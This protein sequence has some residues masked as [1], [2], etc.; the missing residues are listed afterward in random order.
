MPTKHILAKL[1]QKYPDLERVADAVFRAIDLYNG[2]PYAIRYFDLRDDLLSAASRL[3]EYQEGLLG[4]S[5]FR[6]GSKSDLRWNHY[7]Y[8]VTAIVR[9]D[10]AFIRAKAIVESDREYARKIVLT[11]NELDDLLQDRHYRAGYSEDIPSDPL[12]V[13]VD[14]LEE[15]NLGF[16]VDQ[17]LQVPAVVRHIA[18]GR[19]RPVLRPPAEP[20]L[21][22]AEAAVSTDHLAN[23]AIREF[24][25]YP[26]RK[27]FDFGTVNLILG[28]N[29]AGKTSLL[30]AIEYLFCGRTRRMG[31][32]LP[33]TAVSGS[34]SPSNLTLH[35]KTTTRNEKLRSRHLVW[36]GKS[37]LR[38]IRLHDSFS[39]FNFLD[40]DAAVR[41]TVEKSR[42]HII[43]DL[44]QLLLGAE[45]AK[46]LDRFERVAQ[47]LTETKKDIENDILLRDTRRS[48]AA[49][50]LQ[51]LRESP[52]E[53][54]SL[55]SDLLVGLRNSKWLQL[56]SDKRQADE[57]SASL[58]S[59]LADVAILKGARGPILTDIAGLAAAV[60]S[61]T[62]TEQ[63]IDRLAKQDIARK[64]DE[65][66]MRRALQQVAKRIEA[67]NALAPIV[68]AGV[69]DLHLERRALERQ[70]REL[71]V[72]LPEAEAAVGGLP[73]D[74]TLR[75]RTLSTVVTEATEAVERMDERIQAAKEA[76]AEFE[77]GQTRLSSLR[78]RLR[79]SVREIIQH[80][81]DDEHCPVCQAEY[82][83]VELD[84][85]LQALTHE[86]ATSESDR[87][88]AELQTAETLHQ[89]HLS[90]LTALQALERCIR[91]DPTTI[92]LGDAISLAIRTRDQA[93]ALESKLKTVREALQT[94]E[95]QG[96]TFERILELLSTAALPQSEVSLDEIETMQASL[97]DERQ[98]LL[99]TVGHLETDAQDSLQ[100]AAEI[101]APFGLRQPTTTELAPVV[102]DRRRA[103]EEAHR[104]T[105]ALAKQLDLAA[106][107]SVSE[108]QAKLRGA[109]D[110]VARLRTAVAK[111]DQDT[112]A[113]ERDSKLVSDAVAEIKGLRVKLRRVDSA[114]SVLDDLLTQQSERV[115]AETALRENASKIASTFARIHAPNEFDL[116]VNGG[117]TI[118][119]RGGGS[120]DLDEMSS[121][122]RAAYAL[123]LFL[124]MNERLGS[125]PRVLLL[126]DPVAHVDDIN[127][128]SLLD[129]LRDI[130][131]S[132]ER[133]IFFA[134]ADSKIG[135]L[136]GRK[137]RFLGD[138]FAQIEL[139]RE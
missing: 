135:A 23:I 22:P 11:E 133:Q 67:I 130:A 137:F 113:I 68:A 99:E 26:V 81:G 10:E 114:E 134:T 75:P 25:K 57:L 43:D 79:S 35:T 107:G 49:A 58:Q 21:E 56:P 86:L 30:E 71:T 24:R 126:D 45:A 123:S 54:D 62:A 105:V 117:L 78:Q 50:R 55:F 41:L 64:R 48:D 106:A 82:S 90:E 96:W 16:V 2:Q 74:A 53:S 120:V 104:A 12:S 42:D 66:R 18:D 91:R 119:R 88:R 39:K 8:F 59:A 9:L 70:L 1:Q 44:A 51:L 34:L 98:D 27:K 72:A 87:L 110:L 69:R 46:A 47:Q 85:R 138:R 73:S 116:Q 37:E 121:G 93:A 77:L 80:T 40:T 128:L 17:T 109:Q 92:P 131:L 115:L 7:L 52:R 102:S 38:T 20:H 129:H 13:W 28:V 111:E 132:G 84:K 118:V 6:A 125:G 108:V 124:A 101:G 89:Q 100:R 31:T 103:A 136:F 4:R 97:R 122:Q 65:V 76:L 5:Y 95:E 29:G 15:Y 61:L 32:A 83:A 139:T 33:G 36:Y 3:H 127:I 63:V 60:Q 19:Q 14:T 94:H 112:K